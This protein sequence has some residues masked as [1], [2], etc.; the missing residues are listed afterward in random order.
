MNGA[1]ARWFVVVTLPASSYSTTI[2]SGS[3]VSWIT[4]FRHSSNRTGSA[5]RSARANA[6]HSWRPSNRLGRPG[7]AN[8]ISITTSSASALSERKSL[9]AFSHC[10]HMDAKISRGPACSV[11]TGSPSSQE[12]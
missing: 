8:G 2:T 3:A 7:G 4:T 1:A 12:R 9:V 5:A 10:R 6:S 11:I